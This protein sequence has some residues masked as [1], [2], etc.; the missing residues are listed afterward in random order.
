[1][2]IH[3]WQDPH[4]SRDSKSVGQGWDPRICISAKFPGGAMLLPQGQALRT[5]VLQEY[6]KSQVYIGILSAEQ[7]LCLV[8]NGIKQLQ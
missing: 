4:F 2:L 3:S 8:E 7:F 6:P 1:L 5:T